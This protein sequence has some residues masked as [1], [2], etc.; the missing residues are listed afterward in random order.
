VNRGSQK[1]TLIYY[2][3]DLLKLGAVDL[4]SEPLLKRK[5]LLEGLVEGHQRI[6]YVDHMER[7]GLAMYAGT[8]ALALEGVVAKDGQSPYIEGPAENRFW[9]KI[10]N[11]DF[12]RKEPLEFRQNKPR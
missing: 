1:G 3:F 8:L 7:E 6:L 2:V 11:R 4:R 5:K 10:K 9:L 12:K